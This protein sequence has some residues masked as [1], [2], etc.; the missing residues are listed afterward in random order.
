MPMT[1]YQIQSS[2]LHC[3]RTGRELQAGERFYSVLYDRGAT[4]VREDVSKEA[5]QGPPTDAFS[6][7]VSKAPPKDQAR[8]LVIDDEVLFDCL[9]RLAGD[10]DPQKLS[11]R[12][13]VAL[14]LM[15][16]KRLKFA[17]AETWEGQEV[18]LLRDSR[19][20]AVHRVVNPQLTEQ[21]LAAVQEEVEKVLGMM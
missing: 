19:T 3:A 1:G 13:I 21:Q 18:L 6:F 10:N 9:R 15:R 11:F 2:N 20:R 12:Y 17:D 14:L 8:R 4:L 16:R 5:W 7:W